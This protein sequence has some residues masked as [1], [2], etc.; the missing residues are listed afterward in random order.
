[1]NRTLE[2]RIPFSKRTLPTLAGI[3]LAIFICIVPATAATNIDKAADARQQFADAVRMRT[4][5]EGYL[6]KDRSVSDY[7]KTIDA[8][9]KVYDISS[10]A[11]EAPAALIAEAELYEEM[12]HLYDQKYYD[13]A[14]K[15]YLSLL[16]QYPSSQYRTAALI[17]IGQIQKDD[18]NKPKEAQ[19]TFRDFL[20]R[21]P[22]SQYAD[23]ARKALK[24]IAAGNSVKPEPAIESAAAAPDDQTTHPALVNVT[25]DPSVDGTVVQPREDEHQLSVVKDLQ[26]SEEHTSELQS[27]VHLVCRLLLEK[28]KT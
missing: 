18:Q 23:D 24:D 5:L 20:K 19:A 21:F 9:Q 6:E 15:T 16:D 11:D 8:Y 14:I 2:R 7:K 26:R 28:K 22:R 4:S 27:P 1:M 12:G 17:G 25:D 10:E 3:A 13:T